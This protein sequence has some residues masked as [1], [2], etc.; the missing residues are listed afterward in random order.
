M[1][2]DFKALFFQVR[3]IYLVFFPVGEF[4]K[5]VTAEAL[6]MVMGAFIINMLEVM[7][8][9]A[10]GGFPD[11]PGLEKFMQAAVNRCPRNPAVVVFALLDQF[12]GGKMAVGIHNFVKDGF[13]SFT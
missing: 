9:V 2:E 11:D 6:R 8:L 7:V 13:T 4:N 5:L 1:A 12:F 3:L 10:K